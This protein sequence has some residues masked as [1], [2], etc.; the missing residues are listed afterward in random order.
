MEL[1]RLIP[2]RYMTDCLQGDLKIKSPLKRVAARFDFIKKADA[3]CKEF[4]KYQMSLLEYDLILLENEIFKPKDYDKESIEYDIAAIDTEEIL[5]ELDSTSFRSIYKLYKIV[6]FIITSKC[7]L[8]LDKK[9]VSEIYKRFSIIRDIEDQFTIICNCK[10]LSGYMDKIHQDG[11]AF[12][13]AIETYYN[14][15]A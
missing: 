10:N 4:S 13:K 6:E 9:M 14:A 5:K 15:I 8:N 2:E 7:I 12:V 11:K 1:D 3:I